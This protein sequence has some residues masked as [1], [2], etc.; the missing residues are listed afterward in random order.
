MSAIRKRGIQELESNEF[1]QDELANDQDIFS[2]L[3]KG[4]KEEEE[5]WDESE[6]VAEVT[7]GGRDRSNVTRVKKLRKTILET[8]L[9]MVVHMVLLALFLAVH[10]HNFEQF[11]KCP[12]PLRTKLFYGGVAFGGLWKYLTH[13][14]MVSKG[15]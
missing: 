4:Q 8:G 5:L 6:R 12:E 9:R 3:S 7:I 15:L 2:A 1:D 10:V 14:C 11:K 13:I